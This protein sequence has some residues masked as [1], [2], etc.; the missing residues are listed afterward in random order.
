MVFETSQRVGGS[1]VSQELLKIQ[2]YSCTIWLRFN[3]GAFRKPICADEKFYQYF[4]Y[5]TETFYNLL[6][7]WNYVGSCSHSITS[8]QS[9][10][11][12]DLHISWT[13]LGRVLHTFMYYFKGMTISQIHETV[14]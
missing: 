1:P 12:A 10:E 14:L 13:K 3:I 6:Q 2:L 9:A 8:Q 5:C 4:C 11:C 7:M